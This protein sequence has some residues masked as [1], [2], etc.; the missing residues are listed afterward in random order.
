MNVLNAVFVL[1]SITFLIFPSVAETFWL[2][3]VIYTQTVI[4][5]QF[6]WQF[7]F[8]SDG[9]EVPSSF[10]WGFTRFSNMW[11]SLKFHL[12]I[13][14]FAVVQF[15]TYELLK[16]RDKQNEFMRQAV[17]LAPQTLEA[18]GTVK[19][20]LIVPTAP[21]LNH[22]GASANATATKFLHV[23]TTENKNRP[24]LSFDTF[25]RT[26]LV[27]V[28]KLSRH[29]SLAV[30]LLAVSLNALLGT[31]LTFFNLGYL[32]LFFVCLL[33]YQMKRPKLVQQIWIVMCLYPATLATSSYLFQF[34][35]IQDALVGAIGVGVL[36]EVGLEAKSGTFLF[37]Y[38]I[39]HI[40][41]M[42]LCVYQY[43]IFNDSDTIRSARKQFSTA[44]I[45]HHSSRDHCGVEQEDLLSAFIRGISFYLNAKHARVVEVTVRGCW[46]TVQRVCIIHISK[47]IVVSFFWV[48]MSN[49]SA[50][51]FVTLVMLLM[52]IPFEPIQKHTRLMFLLWIEV[53]ADVV[54]LS[55]GIIF[56][57]FDLFTSRVSTGSGAAGGLQSVV[58]ILPRLCSL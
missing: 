53:G 3:L 35:L 22:E 52:V 20:G 17:A 18:G 21:T 33:L 7:H 55:F 39:R 26:L 54:A 32:L 2:S 29:F 5:L 28:T 13:L 6:L 4:V 37:N 43:R 38:L 47:A 46:E 1:F 9:V 10:L 51:G 30:C 15:N 23:E 34:A 14:L 8:W 44:T 12:I 56:V 42:F 57:A 50:L 11:D 25:M 40:L 41:V 24:H 48:A 27:V 58:C 19:N 49:V 36:Q 45:H 16:K 31:V